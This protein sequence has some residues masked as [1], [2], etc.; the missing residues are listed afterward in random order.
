MKLYFSIHILYYIHCCTN[1]LYSLFEICDLKTM[2]TKNI[3]KSQTMTCCGKNY[4][5]VAVN[6]KGRYIFFYDALMLSD[7]KEEV[8]FVQEEH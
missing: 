1:K 8:V 6:S 4:S 5:F 3:T 2:Y 7:C